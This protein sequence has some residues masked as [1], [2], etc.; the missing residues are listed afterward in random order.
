MSEILDA[1]EKRANHI[2]ELMNE[3][4]GKTIVI[5]KAN[6]P[7]INKNPLNMVFICRYYSELIS[8]TFKEKIV[9]SKQI[10]SLDGDYMYY[11]INEAGNVVKEKTIF[12]EDENIPKPLSP[13][14]YYIL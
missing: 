3:F 2:Q 4:T 7:G 12:I 9:V 8:N 10:K 11:V 5:M 6:V 13:L 14:G 1:R